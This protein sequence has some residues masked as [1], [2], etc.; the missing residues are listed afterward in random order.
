MILGD[1]I[2]IFDKDVANQY[3]IVM[4]IIGLNINLSKSLVSINGTF[5]FA[6]RLIFKT[7]DV[8]P[9]SFKE[10]DVSMVSLDALLLLLKRFAGPDWKLSNLFRAQGVGFRAIAN[11]TGNISKLS[12]RIR[13]A[14]V[15]LT[16]PLNSNWSFSNYTE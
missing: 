13:L 3:L 4:D 10:L 6:K 15:W 8:S 1:D 5:E 12:P 2:V 16:K 11:L 9:L 7:S 14:L